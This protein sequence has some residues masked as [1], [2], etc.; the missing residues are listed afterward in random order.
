[1]KT[2]SLSVI[3]PVRNNVQHIERALKSVQQQY[4]PV[5]EIIVVDDGSTDGSVNQVLALDIPNLKLIEQVNQGVGAARNNGAKA[6]RND[7]VVFL[8]PNDE[9]LP[10]FT[11]EIQHLNNAFPNRSCYASRYQ[12]VTNR[13]APVDANVKLSNV[14]P[15][16]YEMTNF[17]AV[18]AKG[19]LPFALSSFVIEKSFFETLGGFVT[20]NPSDDEHE[21]FAKAA[22]NA[23]IAYSPNIHLHQHLTAKKL[24]NVNVP[25][26]MRLSTYRHI[27]HVKHSAHATNDIVDYYA[28][29]LL[30]AAKQNVLC[31]NLSTALQLLS[32]PLCKRRYLRS[33]TLVC[34]VRLL[35]LKNIF[36][37][38]MALV[39]K[40]LLS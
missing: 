29:I 11:H 1:M 15:E 14:N 22:L 34:C 10:F 23:A 17:F 35:Q 20:Q 31:S 28:N 6:A 27:K 12:W 32:L 13:G 4:L 9:W 40:D 39:K 33:T 25:H 38:S 21:F 7:F 37:N 26:Q 2:I 24:P 30:S 36:S 19:E 5:D 16:G 18:A 3:I 8:N